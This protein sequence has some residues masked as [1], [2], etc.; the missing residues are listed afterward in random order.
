[1]NTTLAKQLALYV[2]L[3]SPLQMAA[4]LPENYLAH[5]DAF[6]FI[7]DVPTDWEDTRVLH[8]RIGD[9]VTIVRRDRGGDDW[10]LGSVTDEV[11]RIASK[12]RLR[13]S[14]AIRSTSPKFT[15]TPMMPI[16][17][18]TPPP[19]KSKTARSTRTRRCGCGS[20]PAA[21]WP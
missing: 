14:T 13:S 15:A 18:R 6:Q 21:A 1:M 19:T 7:R 17:K 11:G 16:G 2:V 5:P 4:D 10:Y 9:Y 20:P 12:R 3:Y 8:A